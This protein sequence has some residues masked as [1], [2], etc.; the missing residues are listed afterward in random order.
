M[1][2]G[3]V[4]VKES[5]LEG[6]QKAAGDQPHKKEEGVEMT[7]SSDFAKGENSLGNREEVIL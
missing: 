2:E 7:T 3:E 4:F 6:G 5:V 1:A